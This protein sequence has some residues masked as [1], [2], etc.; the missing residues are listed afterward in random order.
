MSTT[1]PAPAFH[2]T[3]EQ[4]LEDEGRKQSWLA[5][6]I[7]V[8]RTQMNYWVHGLHCPEPYRTQIAE[9]LGRKPAEVFPPEAGA[10]A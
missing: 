3:L 9:A 6:Q 4:I 8:S 10:A 1:D 5:E 2:S 7:G